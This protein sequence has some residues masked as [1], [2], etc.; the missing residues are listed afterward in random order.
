MLAAIPKASTLGT[1]TKGLGLRGRPFGTCS[2]SPPGPV[3]PQEALST[4]SGAESS[5]SFRDRLKDLKSTVPVPQLC[6]LQG[7]GPP[8][9]T[10]PSLGHPFSDL[11]THP[12]LTL[13]C[14]AGAQ[15]VHGMHSEG[16]HAGGQAAAQKVH[17]E[18][19]GIAHAGPVYQLGQHFKRQK[20]QGCVTAS[21]INTPRRLP[22]TP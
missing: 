16:G 7:K 11:A 9:L 5:H 17:G 14:K 6:S 2:L 8:P 21:W 3:S 18:V 12:G 20:L 19:A 22:S 13:S 1:C 10:R 4:L 15:H